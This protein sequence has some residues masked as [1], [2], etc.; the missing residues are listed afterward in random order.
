M[1]EVTL[2]AKIH[3]HATADDSSKFEM[4]TEVY[5]G[6]CDFVSEQ[7]FWNDYKLSFDCV[8]RNLYYIIRD[9]FDLKAQFSQ[10]VTKTVIAKYK[11][12]DSQMEPYTYTD[13][14]GKTCYIKR[15]HRWLTK[16]VRFNRPQADLVRNRDYSF[17]GDKLSIN[18]MQGR[19]YVDYDIPEA[20]KKYFERT[21]NPWKLGT[22][23]LVSLN[24]E[25]YLHIPV[26]K[27]FDW[28]TE[29]F[30]FLKGLDRGIRFIYTSF[31]GKKTE[32]LSGEELIEK[33]ANFL[34]VRAE[35]QA[36]G[37]KSAKRRLKK[38]SGREN[39]WMRD[40][41][42]RL[43]KTLVEE[44][45]EKTLFVLEDLSG[46]SKSPDKSAAFNGQLTSWAFYE[47]E[48]MLTYKAHMA[49]CEVIK[50][51][52]AYTSQRCPKCGRINK[53]NRKHDKH[54]YECD[55]CGYKSNDDRVG[56]MNIYHLGELYLQGVENPKYVKPK[57]TKKTKKAKDP[58]KAQ[59]KEESKQKE[60][61]ATS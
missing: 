58:K 42:H 41:N 11:T 44:S 23:K 32:F 8:N 40:V 5:S 17:V 61:T 20:Y 51:N 18:T 22:A 38:L 12:V 50:V 19:V 60:V 37:T 59:K 26:T 43:T 39:R 3:L 52:R 34:K 24:G 31:D 55:K 33:R 4:I 28:E 2:T 57:E 15:D 13:E 47:F 56:A 35:L 54:F 49:G 46:I 53:N 10:S 45:K 14:K 27:K 21:D 48:E 36:R 7:I 25:W 30:D 9:K 29:K 1:N 16:P 6:A